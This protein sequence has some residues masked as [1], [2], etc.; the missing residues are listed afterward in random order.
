MLDRCS[1]EI[2]WKEAG[3]CAPL[4]T[5]S[6]K[7]PAPLSFCNKGGKTLA[8]EIPVVGSSVSL[9]EVLMCSKTVSAEGVTLFI[10]ESLVLCNAPPSTA[11]DS[12]SA[13]RVALPS[14][15]DE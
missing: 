15:A 14:F 7:L 13:Q 10:L 4:D 5:L 11:S 2:A 9:E 8:L 6:R 1:E 12:P 3:R